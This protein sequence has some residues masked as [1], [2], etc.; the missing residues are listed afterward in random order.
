MKILYLFSKIVNAIS[1]AVLGNE[2]PTNSDKFRRC[3][4][5]LTR[6]AWPPF[7]LRQAAPAV[8]A[9]PAGDGSSFRRARARA[10][11]RPV[12][13]SLWAA[14]VAAR[15][16]TSRRG[17]GR[18]LRHS[19]RDPAP[20]ARRRRAPRHPALRRALYVTRKARRVLHG[21]CTTRPTV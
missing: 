17:T 13:F 9:P 11:P 7:P 1:L 19:V 2:L 20:S 4:C 16:I 8:L 18:T 12:R 6:A 21:E 3:E 5:S 15:C 10:A 14:R